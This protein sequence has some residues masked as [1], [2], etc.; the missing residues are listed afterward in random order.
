ML[1]PVSFGQ[2]NQLH[3]KDEKDEMEK[4]EQEEAEE[5]KAA[6]WFIFFVFLS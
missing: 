4:E 5:K 1:L 3:G 6:G 2:S